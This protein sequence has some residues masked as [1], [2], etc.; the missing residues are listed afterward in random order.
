VN[1]NKRRDR[2]GEDAVDFAVEG[3]IGT[4]GVFDSR[5]PLIS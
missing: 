5:F 4:W 2:V 1:K 3:L